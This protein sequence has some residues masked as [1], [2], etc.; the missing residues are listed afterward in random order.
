MALRC[1]DERFFVNFFIRVLRE[2]SL[3]L[4]KIAKGRTY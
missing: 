4:S 1:M 2:L 3:G